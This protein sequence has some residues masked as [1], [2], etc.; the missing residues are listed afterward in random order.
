[1]KCEWCQNERNLRLGVCWSCAEA[2][3]I[4]GDGLGMP[5]LVAWKIVAMNDLELDWRWDKEIG[6]RVQITPEERY[7]RVLKQVQRWL[8]R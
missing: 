2:E 8:G 6:K 1:M 3:S 4:I 7:E 5:Q